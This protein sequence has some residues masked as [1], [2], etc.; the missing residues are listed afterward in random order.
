MLKITLGND[1]GLANVNNSHVSDA[2]SSSSG[3]VFEVKALPPTNVFKSSKKKQLLGMAS[4]VNDPSTRAAL[5]G[6]IE[7]QYATVSATIMNMTHIY[8]ICILL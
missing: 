2:S 3:P 8:L 5:L 1:S 7:N 4:N 6:I